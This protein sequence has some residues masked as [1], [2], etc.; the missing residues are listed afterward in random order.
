MSRNGGTFGKLRTISSSS[1]SGVWDLYDAHQLSSSDSWQPTPKVLS[2]TNSNGTAL[3]EGTSS[4]I[5]VSTEGM[6]DGTTLY[7]SVATVSGTTLTS[8]DFTT[9]D[10]TGSFTINSNS[11]SFVLLPTADGISES[12]VA[13]IEIIR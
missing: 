9:G 10:V 2:I 13:K 3:N 1:T 11:G 8:A 7:Y 12:N 6:V 5:T 4:T